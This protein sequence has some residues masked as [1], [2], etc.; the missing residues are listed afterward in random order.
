MEWEKEWKAAGDRKRVGGE[1]CW[2]L[3]GANM[4]DGRENRA[5]KRACYNEEKLRQDGGKPEV[6]Q[7]EKLDGKLSSLH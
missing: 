2:K 5:R 6:A 7:P 4:R 1:N 3:E